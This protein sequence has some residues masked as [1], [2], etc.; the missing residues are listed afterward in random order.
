[1]S[2]IIPMH[3]FGHPLEINSIVKIAEKYNLIVIEDAAESLGS[4]YEGKHTGHSEDRC[5]EF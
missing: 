4:L 1:M 2:A 3:T 5:I